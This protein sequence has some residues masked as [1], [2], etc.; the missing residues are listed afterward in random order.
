[1]KVAVVG[2]RKFKDRDLLFRT[3]DQLHGITMVISGGAVGADQIA[4]EYAHARGLVTK[5]FF[6]DYKRYGRGAPIKR[7]RLIIEGADIVIA[8]WDGKSKGT[9]NS[10]QEARKLQKT[11]IIVAFRGAG[12]GKK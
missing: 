4:E 9:R 5:V 10:I 7:N 1:M 2:S 8:F 11:I 6:P 12:K 3:L